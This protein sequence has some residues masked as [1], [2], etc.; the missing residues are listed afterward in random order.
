MRISDWSSDVCSSDLWLRN[1]E[2]KVY[3]VEDG[4]GAELFGSRAYRRGDWKITDIGDG[5]W[6]LFDIARAPGEIRDLSR[7][8]S[9]RKAELAEAWENYARRVG[10]I[11]RKS[12]V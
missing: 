6:R 8:H 2:I 5:Q 4:V 11:D 1:P 12:V 9:E 3:G 7:V 10:V